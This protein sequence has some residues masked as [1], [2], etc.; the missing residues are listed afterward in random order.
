MIVLIPPLLDPFQELVAGLHTVASVGGEP[1]WLT[2]EIGEH[3]NW[4]RDGR[5]IVFDADMGNSIKLTSSRGGQPIR[6]VPASITTFNPMA[7]A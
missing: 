4:S 1:R 5:Y 2:D 7:R 6:I 3:P